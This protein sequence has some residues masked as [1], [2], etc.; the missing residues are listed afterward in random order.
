[1]KIDIKDPNVLKR[2]IKWK[3][4]KFVGSSDPSKKEFWVSEKN[5]NFN[6]YSKSPFWKTLKEKTMFEIKY[7]GKKN[8][9]MKVDKK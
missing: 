2:I 7:K 4:V 5:K 6:Y 9:L 1:M 3:R 8:K